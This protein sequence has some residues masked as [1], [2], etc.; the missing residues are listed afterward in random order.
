M[1]MAKL[2][3]Y[4]K[5]GVAQVV[6]NQWRILPVDTQEPLGAGPHLVPFQYWLDHS[7][8]AEIQ[9]KYLAGELGVWIASDADLAVHRD[10]ILAGMKFWSIIAVDFPIFRDGRG[11]SHAAILRERLGWQGELRAIGDVLIDQLL[12][13]AKV[14][15]DSF[16]LRADQDE[17]VALEQFEIIHHRLQND[18]RASRDQLGGKNHVS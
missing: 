13:M 10:V 3:R 4:Q 14:G 7:W 6:E 16:L 1:R 15:F 12:Q 5:G 11:F 18:W 8:S 2:I 9:A 17:A